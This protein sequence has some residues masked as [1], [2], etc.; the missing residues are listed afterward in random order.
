LK[1]GLLIITLFIKKSKKEYIRNVINKKNMNWVYV[2]L[3]VFVVLWFQGQY[4]E[5]EIECRD[6]YDRGDYRP[7]CSKYYLDD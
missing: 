5:K 1:N 4:R 3:F 6:A 2:I 7:D